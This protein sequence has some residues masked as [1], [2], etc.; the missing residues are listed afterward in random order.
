MT[1]NRNRTVSEIRH[2]FDKF[3]G[4]LG[5]KVA[6]VFKKQGLITIEKSKIAEDK[7]MDVALECG[8]EDVRDGDEVW[9]VV[10]D[11]KSFEEVRAGL[12]KAGL[13]FVSA[14]ITQVP[15]TTVKLEGATAET[16]LKFMTQ[17]ED[18]DDVQNVY[19][20]FDIDA[21]LMEKL[22]A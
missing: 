16:M 6:W 2:L 9:E 20:N 21:S 18:H 17:L 13:S 7:L 10:T 22:S 5:E 12:E 3:G 14:E 11:P 1:D 15:T 4:A 8:A 19:A